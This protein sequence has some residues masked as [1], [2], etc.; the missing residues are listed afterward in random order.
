M[1]FPWPIDKLGI[2][3]RAISET[4][5]NPV[6]VAEDGSDEWNTASPAYDEAIAYMSESHNWGFATKTVTLQPSNIVPQ[7][8]AWDTAYPIPNDCVFILWVKINQALTSQIASTVAALTLYDITDVVGAG[9]CV[10]INAQG[11]PP[12]PP[13][14]VTPAIVT[15]KYVSNG[16]AL[17]DSTNGTPTF[18]R[19]LKK[20]VMA[21]LFRG[22]HEDAAEARATEKEAELVLQ[23]A[24]SRYDQQKPKRQF[25]NSRITAARRIRRPWP[26]VG[27]DNWGGSGI[28]G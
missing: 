10:V 13:T 28:P 8:T 9:T 7:D 15:M 20:F 11:G 19:A 26:P 4:G 25:L 1:S 21:G 2:I 17:T 3:N 18:V 27:N 23:M 16:G 12:P 5:D 22:L 6:N 14:P 24:R